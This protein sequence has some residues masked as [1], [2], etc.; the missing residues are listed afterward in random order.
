MNAGVGR[1]IL[2]FLVA[3]AACTAATAPTNPPSGPDGPPQPLAIHIDRAAIDSYSMLNVA[4]TLT[5]PGGTPDTVDGCGGRPT[6]VIEQ[7]VSGQWQAF[8]GGIC[9]AI[10]VGGPLPVSPGT[11]LHDTT[12]V[13]SGEPGTFRL[14]FRYDSNWTATVASA[15][16]MVR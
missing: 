10:L 14:V 1:G 7:S 16:F 5:N 3:T 4:Y 8:G 9:I 11:T 13:G 15:P 12:R 6:P 2:A